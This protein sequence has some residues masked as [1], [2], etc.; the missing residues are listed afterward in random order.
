MRMTKI[1]GGLLVA[2]ILAL[3]SASSASA[4]TLS[5]A[6]SGTGTAVAAASSMVHQAGKKGWGPQ[7]WGP[8]G[9][10]VRP[11]PRA[12]VGR[13]VVVVR[14]W[15]RRPYYGELVAGIALGTIVAVAVAN[16]MPPP[17]EPGL[18]WYWTNPGRTHGYWDYCD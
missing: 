18:C 5:T 12:Y 9:I 1:S 3:T 10:V 16:A 14:P 11:G 7:G 15:V 8:P 6:S 17:P 2:G 13:P 4:A